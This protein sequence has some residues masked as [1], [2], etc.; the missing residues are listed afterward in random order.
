MLIHICHIYQWIVTLH[1]DTIYCRSRFESFCM[2]GFDQIITK[3]GMCNVYVYLF[4]LLFYSYQIK[5]WRIK[6]LCFQSS[7]TFHISC[8][9]VNGIK[10][11]KLVTKMWLVCILAHYLRFFKFDTQ[12]LMLFEIELVIYFERITMEMHAGNK[13]SHGMCYR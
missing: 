13:S 6:S 12:W 7:N 11:V 3:L 10:E 5:K 8:N 2:L 4:Y 1:D 9:N